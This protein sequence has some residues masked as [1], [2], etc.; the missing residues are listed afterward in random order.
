MGVKG[1]SP[2]FLDALAAYDW[3]GNVRELINTLKRVLAVARNEPTLFPFHL[4]THIRVQA[5]RASVSKDSTVPAPLMENIL[6][7]ESLP[8]FRAFRKAMD[9]QYLRELMQSA[10]GDIAAACHLSGLSRSRLYGL[11]KKHEISGSN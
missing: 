3:P 7:G 1:F 2:E 10:G 4:P 9:R 5:A 6:S 11:L 8:V